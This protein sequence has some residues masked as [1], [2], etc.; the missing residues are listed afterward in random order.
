MAVPDSA[1]IAEVVKDSLNKWW[2]TTER[3]QQTL[4]HRLGVSDIGGCREYVRRMTIEE[5]FSD[6]PEEYN[7][8]ALIGTAIGDYA[9]RAIAERFPR[10]RRFVEVTVALPSG[11]THV[12]HPDLVFPTGVLD[13]KTTDGLTSVRRMGPSLGNQF[14]RHLYAAGLVQAGELPEDCWVGN[15]WI[16]RSGRDKD[17]HVQIESYDPIWLS[18]ADEWLSDVIYAVQN[19]EG[20]M[21]D[22]PI[23]WC[24]R[25]CPYFTNCRG[26][27]ALKDRESQGLIDDPFTLDIVDALIEAKAQKKAAEKVI[28]DARRALA[29]V[30]G[31]TGEHVVRWVHISESDVPG[32][33]RAAYDKLDVRKIPKAKR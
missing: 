20:A 16:D 27:D 10:A 4:E 14:Q 7:L 31:T 1:R 15:L 26:E 5:E 18:R 3:G 28:E 9:E 19:G 6:E 2:T 23:E 29:G 11:S 8:T 13:I 12:G 32:F 22:M 21:K 33:K 17:H 30:S 24:E 25:C